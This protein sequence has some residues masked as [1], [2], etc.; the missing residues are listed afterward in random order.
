M[1]T[2]RGSSCSFDNPRTWQ[3]NAA[4]L[5]ASSRENI[6]QCFA[7]RSKIE[8]NQSSF[9][10]EFEV[11]WALLSALQRTCTPFSSTCRRL[12]FQQDWYRAPFLQ[13]SPPS[14]GADLPSVKL[15]R[16]L[17][18]EWSSLPWGN[19]VCSSCIKLFLSALT[20]S[21]TE[22]QNRG[23]GGKHPSTAELLMDFLPYS[24]A[25]SI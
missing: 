4:N 1:C 25:V 18:R 21:S 22:L 5:E 3:T 6:L 11:T 15:Q 2:V 10:W 7:G 23:K 24:S 12:S 13:L 20:V 8:Q 17:Q 19:R 16:L 9:Q 14:A